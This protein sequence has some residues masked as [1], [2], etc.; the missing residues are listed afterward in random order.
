[1]KKWRVSSNI[2]AMTVEAVGVEG[3]VSRFLRAVFTAQPE[4]RGIDRLDLSVTPAADNVND[5]K[6]I[7]YPVCPDCRHK[8]PHLVEVVYCEVLGCNCDRTS[9]FNFP[10]RTE[11]A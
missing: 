11:H 6:G 2:G 7:E 5:W 4:L 1:M 3:A 8:K 10:E 9:V